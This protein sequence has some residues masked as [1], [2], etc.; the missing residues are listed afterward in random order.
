MITFPSRAWYDSFVITTSC[1]DES[2]KREMRQFM[3]TLGGHVVKEW[4]KECKLLVMSQLSVTVKVRV[5]SQ[6]FRKRSFQ[7]LVLDI[8]RDLTFL[9]Y[10]R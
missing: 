8:I 4:R 7:L 3:L 6:F 1:L 5:F 10:F 2:G 9:S